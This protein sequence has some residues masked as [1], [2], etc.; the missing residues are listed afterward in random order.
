MVGD[1]GLR[2]GGLDVG[3]EGLTRLFAIGAIVDDDRHAVLRQPGDLMRSDLAAHQCSV[4]ELADHGILI[5]LW[6]PTPRSG[7]NNR[8]TAGS[9]RR[10]RP[11]RGTSRQGR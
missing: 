10:G 3:S 11:S 8:D 2:G 5:W 7:R 4:V 1:V 9:A 6:R